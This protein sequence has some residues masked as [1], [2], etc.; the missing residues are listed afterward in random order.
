MWRKHFRGSAKANPAAR[1][2]HQRLELCYESAVLSIGKDAMLWEIVLCAQSPIMPY[3]TDSIKRLLASR[4]TDL[5]TEVE[6]CGATAEDWRKLFTAFTKLDHGSCRRISVA[7][8]HSTDLFA[9]PGLVP[10]AIALWRIDKSAWRGRDEGP[11]VE[12]PSSDL[13][14]CSRTVTAAVLQG[15]LRRSQR[16]GIELSRAAR[17]PSLLSLAALAARDAGVDIAEVPTHLTV[18]IASLYHCVS[19]KRLVAS[20]SKLS[21]GFAGSQK[22]GQEAVLAGFN[23]DNLQREELQHSL[24]AGDAWLPPLSEAVFQIR[25][26]QFHNWLCP[27]TRGGQW[28]SFLVPHDPAIRERQTLAFYFMGGRGTG[29]VRGEHD[30][31][32]SIACD[33]DWQFCAA[34]A[35]AHLCAPLA[36]PPACGCLVCAFEARVHDGQEEAHFWRRVHDAQENWPRKHASAPIRN[37]FMSEQ[38]ASVNRATVALA[39]PLCAAASNSGHSEPHPIAA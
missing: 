37:S 18:L 2:F 13:A 10:P 38:P 1:Y 11:R 35:A 3:A 8:G 27:A 22:F 15:V 33:P 31:G 19:C 23:T 16:S 26:D 30:A 29:P 36:S 14:L 34:C 21:R 6:L 17:I 5:S 7:Q 25:P 39:C 12:L 9:Q 24:A 28:Q 32:G 4:S 20:Q